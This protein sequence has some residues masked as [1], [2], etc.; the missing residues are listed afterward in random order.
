MTDIRSQAILP[1]PLRVLAGRALEA[2]LNQATALDPATRDSLDTLQGRHLQVH[3]R[4]PDLAMDI[5][6]EAG[7]WKVRA[8]NADDEPALRV[9]ATP[10]SLLAMALS[11]TRDGD[12]APGKVEISGDAELARRLERLAGNYAPDFEEAFARTFGDVLGVPLAR[13]TRKVFEHLRDS[14]KHLVQDGADWLREEARLTVP[15]GEM[16]DFLDA[17]DHVRERS[18]RLAARIERLAKRGSDA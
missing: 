2:A 3:L 16:D 15:P 13:M 5:G 17:V 7:H 9:S 1:R 18:E 4:G 11:H 14:G 6:I 8:V 10:G 12:M